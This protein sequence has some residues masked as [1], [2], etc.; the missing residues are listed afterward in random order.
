MEIRGVSKQYP[1]EPPVTALDNVSLRLTE[2]ELVAIAGPSGSGKTTLLSIMGTLERPTAGTVRVAGQ[3]TAALSDRQLSG[4]R[5][6][7]IGFVFQQFF[8]VDAV[9][10]LE[11]VANGLLYRGTPKPERL[12]LAATVVQRVGLEHRAQHRPS[13]LSGGEKQRVAIARALIG[14]PAM[15]L[16]D[17]PTGNLDSATGAAILE[18]LARLNQAGT[19]VAVIT[20]DPQVA[21]AMDRQIQLRDGRIVA[22]SGAAPTRQGVPRPW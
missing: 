20:H 13:Q 12:R 1:A 18:L 3:D 2:G 9:S 22:D 4:L 5:A 21:A 11:N 10:V 8:L 6:H 16:A 17:E 7:H 15:L 14:D 19:T